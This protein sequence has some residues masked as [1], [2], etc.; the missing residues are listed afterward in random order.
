ML[1]KSVFHCAAIV[2]CVS[3]VFIQG[4]S[5]RLAGID[6]GSETD[7]TPLASVKHTAESD[8]AVLQAEDIEYPLSEKI[9]DVFQQYGTVGAQVAVIRDGRIQAA[10]SF[11]YADRENQTPVQTDTKFRCASL[12]KLI[13]AMTAMTVQETGSLDIHKDI[14]DYLKYRVRNP[15][16]ADVPITCSM[17]MTHT[18][19]ITDCASFLDSRNAGSEIP[20]QTLL[21]EASSFSKAKPGTRYSYSNFGAAVLADVAECAA[22][23]SFDSLAKQNI[24]QPIGVDASYL[25]AELQ[26]PSLTANLYNSGGVLQWSARRQIQE[27]KN[28]KIGQ[29][30]H[31]YQGNLTIS[32]IDYAKILCVLLN[33]GKYVQKSVLQPQSVRQILSAQFESAEVTQGYCVKRLDQVVKGRPMWCHTGMN[34]GMY[35]SFAMDLSDKSGVVVFT[36]GANAEK[37][38]SELF[39]VC[40]DVIRLIYMQKE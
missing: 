31:L 37:N 9:D 35:S 39:D 33:D 40:T 6:N 1:K 16:F 17:L 14:G 11:G 4:C 12:S 32:A 23:E 27:T 15:R 30:H 29:T 25:A 2:L 10:H 3:I 18:S 22:G 24:F 28:D 20:L 19:S 38:E 26:D 7:R 13:T 36:S 8:L 5:G 34:Y 21:S